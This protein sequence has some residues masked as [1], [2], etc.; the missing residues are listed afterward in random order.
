MLLLLE[1]V[2]EDKYWLVVHLL[3][4]VGMILD[5]LII[6]L[7]VCIAID[8]VKRHQSIGLYYEFPKGKRSKRNLHAAGRRCYAFT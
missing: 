5:E 2:L 4:L 6:N 7:A 1:W 8:A 3:G